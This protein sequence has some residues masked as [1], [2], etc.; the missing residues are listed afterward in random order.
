LSVQILICGFAL[1]ILRFSSIYVLILIKIDVL[2]YVGFTSIFGGQCCIQ[3][4][5]GFLT[6]NDIIGT[7]KLLSYKMMTDTYILLGKYVSKIFR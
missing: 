6:H 4:Y 5:L 3:N 7:F 2:L 1:N